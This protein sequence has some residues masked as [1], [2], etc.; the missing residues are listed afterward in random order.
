MLFQRELFVLCMRPAAAYE[1]S[2]NVVFAA[3][4]GNVHEA[5]RFPNILPRIFVY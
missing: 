3:C 5:S 4:K 1:S 2:T